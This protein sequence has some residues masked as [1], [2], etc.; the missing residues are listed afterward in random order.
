MF[1]LDRISNIDS[2]VFSKL[3]LIESKAVFQVPSV[4]LYPTKRRSFIPSMVS[5]KGVSPAE[6]VIRKA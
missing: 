5:A 4:F 1:L 3:S 6:V 2:M